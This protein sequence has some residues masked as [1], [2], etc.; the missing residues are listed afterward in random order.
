MNRET[1]PLNR[2]RLFKPAIALATSIVALLILRPFYS[3]G[4]WFDDSLNSQMRSM[5]HRFDTSLLDFSLQV[6]VV[7]IKNAGRLLLGWINIYTMFYVFHEPRWLRGLSMI[8][9]LCH[10]A[11]FAWVLTQLKASLRFIGLACLILIGLFQIRGNHDPVAAY[12]GFYQTLGIQ[13]MGSVALM[14]RWRR[15]HKTWLL[16]SSSLIIVWSLTYYEINLV[17][18]PF[19]L[20]VVCKE[21]RG[22]ERRAA[23]IALLIPLSVFLSVALWIK[24]H[25]SAIYAGANIGSLDGFPMA[26]LRQLHSALPGSFYATIGKVELGTTDLFTQAI[27]SRSSWTVLVLGTIVAFSLLRKAAPIHDTDPMIWPFA[28]NLLI[29]PALLISMSARY[30]TEIAWGQ[31]YLPVYYQYFGT[32]IFLT[33]LLT[34]A[35]QHSTLLRTTLPCLLGAYLALNL[36]INSNMKQRL[37]LTFREPVESLKRDLR[38]GLLDSV[39]SGDVVTIKSAPIFVNGNVIFEVTGKRVF[40]PDEVATAGWFK[41]QPRPGA[42]KFV[43]QRI[44][45]SASG[46]DWNLDR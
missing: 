7:W 33:A 14:L 37:D 40:V 26:F 11:L 45:R 13:F 27:H 18:Y 8:F 43:L 16:V 9:L 5:L 30:Q 41:N 10:V 12:A 29:T 32:A 39:Q 1:T 36:Q 17:Y 22:A 46:P 20:L 24:Q 35:A 3:N 28:L 34:V 44:N 23:L 42:Q 2:T 38:N 4:F 6:T 31:G 19:A 15:T 21:T 25:A